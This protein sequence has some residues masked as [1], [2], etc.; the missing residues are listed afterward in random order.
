MKTMSGGEV[1]HCFVTYALKEEHTLGI[2]DLGGFLKS[3]VAR[4]LHHPKTHL[5]Y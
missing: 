1:N 2:Y 4:L 3:V 5:S